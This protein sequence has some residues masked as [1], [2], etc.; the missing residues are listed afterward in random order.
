VGDI[1]REYYRSKKEE[2]EWKS[3]RDPVTLFRDKL[4]ADKTASA[5]DLDRVDAE[6]KAEMDAAVKFA[7]AAPYPTPDKVDQ[8]IYA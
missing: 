8:D 7:I 5:A 1:N 2:Q 6:I 4:I 3:Q